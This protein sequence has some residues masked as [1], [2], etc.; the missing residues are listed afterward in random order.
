MIKILHV[1]DDA[2]IREIAQLALGLSGDFEVVQS[3]SGEEALLM[4]QA[5]VPDVLLLDV[6]MPGMTGRQT[7]E[8]M[9]QIPALEKTPAIFMTARAQN[10][11][12]EELR[13]L[14][15]AEVISKPFD[16][17]LLG[18]QIKAALKAYVET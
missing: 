4:V 8:R 5:F 18:D 3:A 11:E 13:E 12:V 6:M 9:R 10:S 17:M 15:A 1:E 14:G 7:L 16:P 2:D